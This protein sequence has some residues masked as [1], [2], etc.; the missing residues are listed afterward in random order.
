MIQVTKSS[1]VSFLLLKIQSVLAISVAL[2]PQL[3]VVL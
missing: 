3:T 1:P 2:V